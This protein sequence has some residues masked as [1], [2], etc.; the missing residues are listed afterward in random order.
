[1]EL[2]KAQK[3]ALDEI[4]TAIEN[5]KRDIFIQAPTGTGKSL[6]AL[7][8]SRLLKANGQKSYI[9]TSEK[10]LQ[11]Q[12]EADCTGKFSTHHSDVTSISGID[13]Y[14]CDV[15]GEKFSLGVC[16]NLG[17]SNR[18]AIASMPCAAS[19]GYLTRWDAARQSDRV[20]MNYSYWLIQMNYVLPKMYKSP[21]FNRRDVIVCDEAHKIPDI[22]ESHFAC[23][24]NEKIVNRVESIIG[25]LANLGFT[26]TISTKEL[27]TAL[28]H[29]LGHAEGALPAVHH[30]ALKRVYEAY[31]KLLNSVYEV[32]SAITAKYL[33]LNLSPEALKQYSAKLPR[34]ARALF[35]LADDI[36]DQHCK[37]EDYTNMIEVHGLRNLVACNGDSGDRSYHNLS[38]Y[39]L[40]HKHFRRHANVRI[41]MS[42]T[43]QPEL[44]IQRWNL[45]PTTTHI[46]DIQSDWD[47]LKSPIV[48]CATS[49][50]SYGNGRASVDA[51]IKK[52]DRLL[53]S[54]NSERGV[55]HTTTN[56]IMNTLLANSRHANR[57]YTY[58]GT[59]E[60]LDL[61]KR[62]KELP[63]DAVLC[64]PSLY[65]GIDL[66][67]ELARFNI[68]FKL[69]FPN[70]SSQL[71]SRR[72]KFQKDV[73]FGETAAVLE[74]SAGRSTR[75]ADDYSTTYILDNR[76][77]KFILGNKR[78]FSKSFLERVL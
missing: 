66:S 12:Y 1:M 23:R 35:V 4:Q 72:Y 37:V 61:L 71:W 42:A 46:I 49:N 56:L 69:S 9:L 70:V 40:F 76:A 27:Q 77:E 20:L 50:M 74:Q 64:G 31:T 16:R 47:P 22:I 62:L 10:S 57:L 30:D 41:Y 13:T 44:L 26:F 15:N 67:D 11:Q 2:R 3:K 60:K 73:Y 14:T 21:P 28:K 19:C 39:N 34:E 75:H 65:T 8:I 78:Y 55:I 63:H 5:G 48:C 7:E 6:I 51:A 17:L 36:K 58:S 52:I 68:I 43:L 45:N 32:K 59:S 25:A 24:L 33:P 29:A 38:D 53:D 54:H 18:E